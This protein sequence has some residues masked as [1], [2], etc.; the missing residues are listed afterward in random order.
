M[1]ALE[2]KVTERLASDQRWQLIERIV[3]TDPFR[4]SARFRSLLRYLAERALNEHAED[5]TETKIGHKVFSK[6]FDYSP[7]EDSTVR[8]H[9]RQLRLKLHEYFDT[10]GREEL[11]VVEIPKG[12]FMPVFQ[13]NPYRVQPSVTATRSDVQEVQTSVVIPPY[14]RLVPLLIVAVLLL[15]TACTLLLIKLEITSTKITSPWPFSTLADPFTTTTIVTADV[16]YGLLDLLHQRHLSL[17][18]YLAP[19]P[20]D[21]SSL[22]IS[23][24][25]QRSMI[26]YIEKSSLTSSADAVIA[27]KLANTIGNYHGRVS[28]RSARDLRPRDFETG[29]FIFLGSPWSNPWVSEFYDQ[30]NFE[31]V[32][33]SSRPLHIWRNKSPKAGEQ[34]RY[35]GIPS[36]GATGDDYADIA[37]LPS[38]SG[39]GSVLLLQGGQQEGTES[40]LAYL[41]NEAGR[42]DLLRALGFSSPPATAVYFEALIKTQVI[43]G[44]P[45]ATT[46]VATR[47]IHPQSSSE[48]LRDLHSHGN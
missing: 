23:D 44:A 12:G 14:R 6:Q 21:N 27:A 15:G 45:N 43:A 33:D 34:Q 8:V 31:E 30:L 22:H 16:N 37:L 39:H 47:L 7:T 20:T 5:L 10:A 13:E 29:N 1:F 35:E 9:V 18:E 41:V 25:G 17:Q 26:N 46:I 32:A 19:S 48:Q 4:K 11:I 36:T 28:V 40:T 24:P 38:R 2:D 3:A 42:A